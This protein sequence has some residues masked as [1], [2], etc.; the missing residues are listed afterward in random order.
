MT[1]FAAATGWRMFMRLEAGTADYPTLAL[2]RWARVAPGAADQA[3]TRRQHPLWL[4]IKKELRLQQMSLAV[5]GLYAVLWLAFEVWEI[6]PRERD[7]LATVAAIYGAMLALLIGSLAS[8]EERQMGTLEWQSL[9]E[10]A[11]W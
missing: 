4:I 6:E 11:S 3:A 9:P 7:A 5:A 10:F 8:A 1:T 2:P